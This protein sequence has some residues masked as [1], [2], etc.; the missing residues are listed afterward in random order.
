[1]MVLY[2][3][4]VVPGSLEDAMRDFRAEHGFELPHYASVLV[5]GV[6]SKQDEL[7]ELL[8]RYLQEWS[9]QR[10][11]AVERSI[12][13]IAACE[14]SEE[15]VPAEVCIDEAVELAKRYASPEAAKLVNGVLGALVRSG[16]GA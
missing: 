3:L 13:R 7:D 4:D 14:L 15:L 2:K 16:A 1:M 6:V 8:G 10:L 12:L 9:V 11:G 5:Q